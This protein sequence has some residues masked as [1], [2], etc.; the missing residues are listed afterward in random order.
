[1]LL[2]AG[3]ICFLHAN[4]GLAESATNSQSWGQTFYCATPTSGPNADPAVRR[5][6]RFDAALNAA[7]GLVYLGSAVAVEYGA[8]PERRSSGT[9]GFDDGIRE[10]LRGGSLKLREDVATASDATLA[11]GIAVLPF[12]SIGAQYFR[13]HDCLETWDMTADWIESFGLTLF[14]T[15]ASKM[16][17]GRERPYAQDCGRANPPRDAECSSEDRFLSFPSGHAAQAAAGAGLTC[18]FSLQ[19]HAWGSSRSARYTPCALGVTTAVATGVLRITSDR[20]WAT[21]VLTGFAIG[22]IVGYFDTW[23]PFDLLRFR[24]RDDKG[25]VSSTGMVLP[26]SH[27]GR[28]GA[29]LVMVF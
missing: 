28:V 10:G 24:T 25:H 16:V 9:N 18:A 12:A 6:K 23:G 7:N 4:A 8:S 2:V 11:L 26:F 17:I 22:G 15:Q 1:L 5:E 14:L 29:Q 3:T 20:H 13:T 19:R 21:D 27:E